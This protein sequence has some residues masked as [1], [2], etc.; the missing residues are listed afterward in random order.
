V[1]VLAENDP[2]EGGE[3]VT[4]RIVA[5]SERQYLLD[6]ADAWAMLGPDH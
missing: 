5:E 1:L 2:W 6:R 3:L 4:P